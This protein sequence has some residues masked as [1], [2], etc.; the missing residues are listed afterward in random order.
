[1]FFAMFL[2]NLGSPLWGSQLSSRIIASA[3]I[4]LV[5]VTLIS[6]AAV[7]EQNPEDSDRAPRRGARISHQ[8]AFVMRLCRLGVIALVLLA[9]WQLPLLLSNTTQIN[10]RNL[11]QSVRISPAMAKADQFLRQASVAELER[12]WQRFI[13]SGAPGLKYP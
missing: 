12:P 9:V 4:A 1:M 2:L 8:R 6:S 13:A 7:I 5:G 10:Q 3:S 11:S